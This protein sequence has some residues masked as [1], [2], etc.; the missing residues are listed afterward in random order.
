[1]WKPSQTRVLQKVVKCNALASIETFALVTEVKG[2]PQD[3][4]YQGYRYYYEANLRYVE[5]TSSR[6]NL[7]VSIMIA[8]PSST[9]HL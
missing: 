6:M 1:M 4:L 2:Q 8:A 5:T 3:G 9:D 7:G